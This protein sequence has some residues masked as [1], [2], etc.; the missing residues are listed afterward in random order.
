M[1]DNL[2]GEIRRSAV[3]MTYAPG[4]IMDM[5]ADGGPVSAVSAGLEEWDQSAP[6]A[7][8]LKYQKIIERRLCK[9]L[10]KKYFRLPPVLE[11]GAKKPNSEEL[12][13]AALVAR[14]FPQWLQCPS[15]EI[16]R[17]AS[18]WA[19]E[20]GRAY[21]YCAP[22]TSK[23]P[24]GKKVYAVP[25]RFAAA[26]HHGHLDEFPWN[27]WVAHKEGCQNRDEL[28]LTSVGPGLAGLVVSCRSCRSERS[29]GGAFRKKALAGL[30]CQGKRPWLRTNDPSCN[31]SGDDG[32]YRAVQRGAS[33][34]YYPVIES[35]LDIPPWT[36]KLERILGD[37]WDTLADI[38]D[39]QD[40]INYIRTSAS[41]G[42]ILEREGLTASELAE[43][44]GQMQKDLDASAPEDIRPDEYRVLTSGGTERDDEFE[45][46]TESVPDMLRPYFR[47]IVRVARLREVRVVR[48]FTRIN[49]PF[50]T[51]DAAV[52]PI[53]SSALDWL[54]GIEVRG[55]GIF[56]QF[57]P[58][59]LANW[60]GQQEVMQRCATADS[61]WTSEWNARNPDKPKPFSA[62]PR[63]LL[64]HTFAHALI[65]QLT[66]ECGYSTASL[67]ERLYVSE[68]KD[69]M[70][71]LLVYTATPDSDGTLGGLQR[72]AM[73]DL[74]GP[75]VIGAVLS[76]QWCSSDPLC[77]Q[78][79]MAAPESHSIAS[80]HSCTM[81][82]ETSC[83][84]HNGFLDRALIVGKDDNPGLGFFRNI[85]ELE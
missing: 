75:T 37:Y 35:A 9:K 42:R 48:G 1:P 7:G 84:L 11:D 33:N 41:L 14:R 13:P 50:D 30:K 65:R 77:I 29:L 39:L 44:F 49:P 16:L 15:C 56:I 70:A 19:K 8:N 36:R 32:N 28:R 55:E 67:R 17:P 46:Y 27:F 43:R 68:G 40:R 85:V 80:C 45:I 66:L 31:C 2:I 51:E 21:R 38:P 71:G 3:V 76:A 83:E 20:P 79:E 53:S 24:G 6:L 72:R 23:Q 57:E 22:C 58:D 52:S 34:L 61:S 78:G 74:L 60:E 54:P 62:S 47:R 64:V 18:K 59:M 5:R 69:G 63:L 25:V 73:A 10:G 82:P 26:C 12:D 81:V 4:A